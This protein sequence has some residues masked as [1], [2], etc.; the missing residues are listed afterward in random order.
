MALLTP[1]LYSAIIGPCDKPFPFYIKCGCSY[2]SLQI[3]QLQNYL[4]LG[5]VFM[6][7]IE[8][9]MR[10]LKKDPPKKLIIIIINK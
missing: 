8:A 10:R 6:Y 3:P 7:V 5:L 4:L 9:R 2:P 1:N